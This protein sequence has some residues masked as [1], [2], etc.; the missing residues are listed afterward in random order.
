MSDRYTVYFKGTLSTVTP[1]ANSPE[2]SRGPNKEQM[3]QRLPINIGGGFIEVPIIPA[4]T[5]RGKLRRAAARVL[6]DRFEQ[7]GEKVTFNDWLLW[8]VGGVK[9]SGGEDIDPRERAEIIAKSAMLSVFGAGDSPARSMVGASLHVAPGIPTQE[10]RPIVLKGARAHEDKNPLLV[11]I[12]PPEEMD[13]V[14]ILIAANRDRSKLANR[15]K[16]QVR[17][18]KKASIDKAKGKPSKTDD[19]MQTLETEITDLK[20]Q[21][22]EAIEAQ[23][24]VG[25]DTAIGRPLPGYEV[26]PGGLEIPHTMQVTLQPR[27][28]IGFALEALAEFAIDPVIGAHVSDGCGRIAGRYDAFVRRGRD[29][30]VQHVGKISFGDMEGLQVEG[31]WLEECCRAW[32]DLDFDPAAYRAA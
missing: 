17:V 23:K 26:L 24:L 1:F 15:V 8:S 16:A 11:S 29:R 21:L 5:I 4:S 32:A 13:K 7:A 22:D 2:G 31:E 3:L 18:L 19:E 10:V 12:L 28:Y 14:S 30:Q 9:G 20:R 27:E 25:S 6:L